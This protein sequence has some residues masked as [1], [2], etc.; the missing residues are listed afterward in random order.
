[1]KIVVL[2]SGN[3]SNLQ[4]IIDATRKELDAEIAAVISNEPDAFGLER[5]RKANIP[6]HI[7]NHRDFNSRDEFDMALQKQINAYHPDLIVMAGFMRRLGTHFI[8]SFKNKMINIHPSLL[9]KYPGLNTH[10]KVLANHDKEHGI[11]IHFVTLDIDAGPLIAQRRLD[12]LPDDTEETLKSRIQALEHQLYPAV[13]KLFA[14][15][16]IS[17]KN[18]VVLI[19]DQPVEVTENT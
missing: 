8:Q 3:G 2:I 12:V 4:S 6:S 18:G 13:L 11:S 14:D 19:D 16:R 9:P 5:A 15:D 7:V 17:L 10:K 1:M